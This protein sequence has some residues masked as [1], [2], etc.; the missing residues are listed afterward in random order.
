[1][2]RKKAPDQY[3]NQDKWQSSFELGVLGPTTVLEKNGNSTE[4]KTS[5]K[6]NITAKKSPSI[7]PVQNSIKFWALYI[8]YILYSTISGHYT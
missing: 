6:L 4:L 1:M 8:N 2:L 5:I 3:I 7:Q